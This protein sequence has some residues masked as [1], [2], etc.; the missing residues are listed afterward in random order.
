MRFRLF[1]IWCLA[2]TALMLG[3]WGIFCHQIAC[4]RDIRVETQEFNF[5]QWPSD[6][7]PVRAVVLADPHL[8]FWE[9]DKLKHIVHTITE[10]HPDIILLLGDFPYG[11]VNRFSLPE[12]ECYATLAP[13]ATVAPVIYIIGNHDWYYHHMK[14]EFRRLGFINSGEA[15]RRLHL[16][17]G[18]T[19][20]IIGFTWSYGSKLDRHLPN[21]ITAAGDVPLLCIAHYPESFYRHPLPQ[22]DLVVAGHTHGGQI[23][24]RN[25]MPIRTFGVLHPEQARGGLHTR[26]DGKPLYISRG[27]GMSKFPLRLN[28]PAE[29]SLLLLKGAEKADTSS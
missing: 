26:P 11:V 7:P 28:C 24:D 6:T 3:A 13:L 23:C 18:Q 17:G 10:L 21:N 22:V 1:L 14:E 8:A 15:T 5:S 16:A 27:I 4:S 25:G 12:A 9:G 2:F 19:L 20:D 29:I